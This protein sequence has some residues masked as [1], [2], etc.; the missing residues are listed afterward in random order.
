MTKINI[1]NQEIVLLQDYAK[2]SPLL[3]VQLKAYAVL[4]A[5]G[6]TS[7]QTIGLA[8]KRQPR[9]ISLWLNDWHKHRIASLF[10]GHQDNNNAGKLTKVQQE[11]IKLVLQSSP[12]NYGLPQEFWDVPQLK[13]YIQATFGIVYESTSSYHFLLT[14]SN[15]INRKDFPGIIF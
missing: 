8:M 15:L 10:T 4:L 3:L 11:E 6:G 2:T 14:F 1:T 5:Y 9:T 7:K 13:Q 12:S